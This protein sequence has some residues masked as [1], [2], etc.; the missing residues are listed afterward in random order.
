MKDIIFLPVIFTTFAQV[1]LPETAEA[2]EKLT[3]TGLS[4]A[5]TI[6][7]WRY[8]TKREADT[9]AVRLEEKARLDKVDTI[10][11]NRLLEVQNELQAQIVALLREQ[12][13]AVTRTIVE[14]TDE[15]PVINKPKE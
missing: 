7:L 1:T 14:N 10:E 9:T 3:L 8:F 2:W 15:H 13:N 5:V 4:I 6:Y 11:R 12:A